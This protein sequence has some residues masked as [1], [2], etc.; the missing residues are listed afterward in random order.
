[1]RDRPLVKRCRLGIL[2][3]FAIVLV[4]GL[5]QADRL[6]LKTY[7]IAD[8]LGHNNVNKIVRD[9]RGFLWFCTAGGLSKFDGYTFTNYGAEQGLP[10]RT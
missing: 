5:T 9:S 6:P 3:C 1:M 4:S 7:T 8:G 2:A 10:T